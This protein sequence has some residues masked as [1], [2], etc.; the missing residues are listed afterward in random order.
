MNKPKITIIGISSAI[1]ILLLIIITFVLLPKDKL[2]GGYFDTLQVSNI[3]V[4]IVSTS[5]IANEEKATLEVVT[6]I[7][8]KTNK[9]VVLNEQNFSLNQTKPTNK[10]DVKIAKNEK[11]GVRQ[12]YPYQIVSAYNVL[13]GNKKLAFD[14]TLKNNELKEKMIKLSE[15]KTATIQTNLEKQKEKAD[16]VRSE[17][18]DTILQENE[19]VKEEAEKEKASDAKTKKAESSTNKVLELDGVFRSNNIKDDTEISFDPYYTISGKVKK[20]DDMI[21]DIQGQY[22][23]KNEENQTYIE[24]QFPFEQKIMV[25]RLLYKDANTLINQSEPISCNQGIFKR[26]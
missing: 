7:W 5:V 4:R 21:V 13:L 15:T 25:A 6:S 3:E 17:K 24:I 22:M 10:I 19:K 8:N 9:E 2:S 20:C 12:I 26:K 11:V 1:T 23:I 18:N 16:K 14:F